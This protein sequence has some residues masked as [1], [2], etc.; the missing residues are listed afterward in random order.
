VTLRTRSISG[1]L[2]LVRAVNEARLWVAQ[3]QRLGEHAIWREYV[4]KTEDQLAAF[5]RLHGLGRYTQA[6]RR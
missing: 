1:G 6:V 2:R 5:D 4:A 3:E